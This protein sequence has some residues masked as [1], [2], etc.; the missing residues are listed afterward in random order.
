MEDGV[1]SVSNEPVC[2]GNSYCL[3]DLRNAYGIVGI[4]IRSR[5]QMHVIGHHTTAYRQN[6]HALGVH[7][8]SAL[9]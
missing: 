2:G 7:S 8:W 5:H 9:L 6:F 1:A 4:I 3:R